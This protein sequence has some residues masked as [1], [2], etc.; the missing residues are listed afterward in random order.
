MRLANSD[1]RSLLQAMEQSFDP[2]DMPRLLYERFELRW[3]NLT[4][5]LK[6]FSQQVYD[7]H[8]WFHVR[9]RS[10]E[11]VAM[12]RD[13]RPRVTELAA[14]ADSLGFT[15][16]PEPAELEVLVRSSS[17]PY[18]DVA[19][20]QGLLSARVTAVCRV[21]TPTGCGTGCLI[22]PD[23]VLTNHHVVADV[24][25]ASHR[26]SGNLN[27]RF[28]YQ[29]C[30]SGYRTPGKVIPA[31]EL[32]AYSCGVD[33]PNLDYALLRLSTKIGHEPLIPGGDERGFVSLPSALRM[34]AVSEAVLILQHPAGK[35]I[36]VDLGSV[37]ETVIPD[38][39]LKHNANTEPGSSGAPVFNAA[40]ELVAIHQ[41][42]HSSSTG[43]GSFNQAIPLALIVEHAARRGVYVR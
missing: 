34:P 20:F 13:A 23:V 18:R 5:V 7:V 43:E 8:D 17:P 39:R 25:D 40:L 11:L 31:S 10:E 21:E 42:G 32:L 19:A 35:P 22:A 27:C 29:I 28:D 38:G 30:A 41:G 3:A 16:L 14:I 37:T 26:F 33:R 1:V 2:Q 24:I 36:K 4:S 12:L 6:P 9:N 15:Q